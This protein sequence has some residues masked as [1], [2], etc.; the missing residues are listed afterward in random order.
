M[1]SYLHEDMLH[2]RSV[3]LAINQPVTSVSVTGF[4]LA[5][6]LRQFCREYRLKHLLMQDGLAWGTP[7]AAV[8]IAPQLLHWSLAG[9]TKLYWPLDQSVYVA[10]L[11]SES[12]YTFIAENS[13]D[14]LP[15]AD[16]LKQLEEDVTSDANIVI[17]AGGRQ[18]SELEAN[19]YLSTTPD[20]E[21]SAEKSFQTTGAALFFLRHRLI[22]PTHL[23]AVIGVLAL[24]VIVAVLVPLSTP[25]ATEEYRPLIALPPPNG[26]PS[27]AG[28]L[29]SLAK[30]TRATEV[31]QL[32]GL[33]GADIKGDE[34]TLSGGHPGASLP[35]L[36]QLAGA[37]QGNLK[38]TPDD[39]EL[40]YS[41]AAPPAVDSQPLLPVVA[42]VDK[43]AILAKRA[44]VTAT[45]QRAA[46]RINPRWT[47][48]SV[49][50]SAPGVFSLELLA[51]LLA[52]ADP[53]P[54]AKL[55]EASFVVMP[56][57]RIN[58]SMTVEV[59]GV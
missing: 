49:L 2:G 4:E 38:G 47:S 59:R 50:M 27:L 53:A 7:R 31:L 15:P 3:V 32:Y 20:Y 52:A 9:T 42:E 37:L 24:L 11:Q 25:T 28:E 14:A 48:M 26:R 10:I 35:R 55:Q 13:E 18:T 39:W 29:T 8:T 30:A 41:V 46:L 21:L 43:L 57:G 56:D 16:A 19:G 58:I 51:Q 1:P 22:H 40:E 23:Y 34:L 17:V 45:V 54:N 33:S 44:N 5:G 12:G 36:R 6:Q